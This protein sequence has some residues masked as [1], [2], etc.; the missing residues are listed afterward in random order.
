[1]VVS[2]WV[3][4]FFLPSGTVCKCRTKLTLIKF[5]NVHCVCIKNCKLYRPKGLIWMNTLPFDDPIGASV[6]ANDIQITDVD[7][8]MT[9]IWR[10]LYIFGNV[11]AVNANLLG[12]YLTPCIEH[13]ESYGVMLISPRH[14]LFVQYKLTFYSY[15]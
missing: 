8:H 3:V 10:L 7:M 9:T 1:M 6:N 13:N 5:R 2:W 12:V 15:F 4:A 11:G 14:L